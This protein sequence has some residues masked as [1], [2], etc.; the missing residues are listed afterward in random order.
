MT[1]AE[2]LQ[3]FLLGLSLGLLWFTYSYFYKRTRLD[4]LRE[5]LFTIRDELFDY[6]WRHQLSYDLPA[7]GLLRLAI[8]GMIRDAHKLN[9]W[10]M[11]LYLLTR[12]GRLFSS[13]RVLDCIRDVEVVETRKYLESVYD[14]LGGRGFHYIATE[15]PL[16][17]L[18]T[19]ALV[20]LATATTGFHNLRTEREQVVELGAEL[21][22]VETTANHSTVSVEVA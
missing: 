18:G 12:E 3:V 22:E 17:F 20:V 19:L 13:S 7:Y 4:A 10:T 16:A 9:V 15:G 5:D 21:A 6:V 2:Q 14:R 11:I 8:N 1:E